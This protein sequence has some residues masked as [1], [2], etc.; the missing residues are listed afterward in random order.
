MNYKSLLLCTLVLGGPTIH[1]E[2]VSEAPLQEGV[3]LENESFIN[4]LRLH[5]TI[6]VLKKIAPPGKYDD[7]IQVIER[8]GAIDAIYVITK[9]C[10]RPE[11]TDTKTYSATS[12]NKLQDQLQ[13]QEHTQRIIFSYICAARSNYNEISSAINTVHQNLLDTAHSAMSPSIT[14]ALQSIHDQLAAKVQSLSA[15]LPEA[16]RR[17]PNTIAPCA[18]PIKEATKSALPQKT[19]H[20]NAI[21]AHINCVRR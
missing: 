5:Y 9:K 18:L 3:S 13:K 1:T 7:I 11:H 20:C 4:A 17:Q 6:Q 19:L 2:L 14:N 8:S 21:A 16:R 15:K 10:Q 12:R